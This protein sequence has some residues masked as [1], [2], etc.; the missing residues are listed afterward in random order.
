MKGIT[1]SSAEEFAWSDR[2]L[3]GHGV[4]DDTHK[5]FVVC[6]E[7]VLRAS[8]AQIPEALEALIQ[9]LEA[10]FKQENAW[11]NAPNFPGGGECHIEEHDKVL[12]SAYQVQDVV[13]LGNFEVA[14]SYARAV[15]DWFPGHADYMDSALAAWLVKQSHNGRPLVFRR[16]EAA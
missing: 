5:E 8:D 10:H 16:K 6:V 14:R 4:M 3:L 1:M 9:H 7:Q 11:L 2:Y 13:A 12:S 15:A